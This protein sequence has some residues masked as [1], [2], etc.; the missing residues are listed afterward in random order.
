[1]EIETGVHRTRARL[2]QTKTCCWGCRLWRGWSGSH[3]HHAACVDNT[4]EVHWDWSLST[5]VIIQTTK[6]PTTDTDLCFTSL[7]CKGVS[8][9]CCCICAPK[10]IIFIKPTMVVWTWLVVSV[11]IELHATSSYTIYSCDSQWN[12][13]RWRA[14]PRHIFSCNTGS[15][16]KCSAPHTI[17]VVGV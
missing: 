12:A 11:P 13:T 8:V 3:W 7:P 9:C 15:P 6:F 14:L 1:M 10:S 2:R 17:I 4:G 16:Q 5:I